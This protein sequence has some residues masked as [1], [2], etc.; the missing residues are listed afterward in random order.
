MVAA[1]SDAE[2][3]VPNT[4]WLLGGI[5]LLAAAARLWGLNFGLPYLYHPDEP[6]YV[7]IA[8]NMFKTGDWNPHSFVFPSLFF[9]INAL[10]YAPFYLLGSITGAFHS[11][12]DIVG[13]MMLTSSGVGISPRPATF[14]LGRGVSFL[15]GVGAVALV[16]F[17]GKR[18]TGSRVV[19]LLGAL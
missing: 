14:L 15:F 16:Y 17:I 1:S 2:R 13:P 6:T 3:R 10:A 9:D 11:T 5:V 19:G 12:N 7:T 4:W 8:Q 18:L